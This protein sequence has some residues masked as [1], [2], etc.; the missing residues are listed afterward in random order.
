MSIQEH[1]IHLRLLLE[2]RRQANL[3]VNLRKS[4]FFRQKIDYLGYEMSIRGLSAEPDKVAAIINFPRPKNPK[5]L[6]GFLRL[7][8]FYN[9]FTSRYA[10]WTQ[11]LLQLLKKGV[12]F[13]W[14][15]E[16]D[17]QF[18]EVKQL[19]VNTVMLRHPNPNKLFYLQTDASKYALGC[20]LYTSRCV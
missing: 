20:L 19:F 2:N 7:T 11:P 6:K 16:L 1:I 13:K 12:K 3:T 5:Q 10:E 8:N 17:K 18:E 15:K 14:T 4:K 9:K